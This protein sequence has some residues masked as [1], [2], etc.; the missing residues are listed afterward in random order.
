MDREP[1]RRL[2]ALMAEGGASNKGLARRVRDVA[3]RHG[4]RVGTTHV[5]V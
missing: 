4:V 1:N 3:L 2:A 5:S